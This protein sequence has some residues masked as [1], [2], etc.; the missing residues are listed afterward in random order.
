MEETILKHTRLRPLAYFPHVFSE[1]NVGV[2]EPLHRFEL[3]LAQ[4]DSYLALLIQQVAAM[5]SK[6]ELAEVVGKANEFLE[7][8][9]HSIVLLQIAKVR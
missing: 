4:A 2:D 6:P 3:R 8:V 9:K 5:E 1:A 7:A